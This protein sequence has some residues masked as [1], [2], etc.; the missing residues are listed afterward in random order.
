LTIKDGIV[1]D[2]AELLADVRKMTDDTWSD[3]NADRPRR[4][5]VGA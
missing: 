1:F 4:A 3:D 2:S 5:E